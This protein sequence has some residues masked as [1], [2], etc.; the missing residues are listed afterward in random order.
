MKK[1][2]VSNDD[3]GTRGEELSS[4]LRTNFKSYFMERYEPS[5]KSKF[6]KGSDSLIV[7]D[8]NE[9]EL[10]VGKELKDVLEALKEYFN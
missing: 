9:I 3:G 2:T 6:S 1:A 4:M 7:E 8:P 10:L 5:K